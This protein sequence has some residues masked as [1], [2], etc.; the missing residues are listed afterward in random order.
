MLFF[1][2]S[3]VCI[4]IC[5][6]LAETDSVSINVLEK[7]VTLTCRYPAVKVPTRQVAAVY[8]NPVGKIAMIKQIF[9]SSCS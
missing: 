5:D 2:I 7:K 1:Y 8:R 4:L 6:F 9:R 3:I